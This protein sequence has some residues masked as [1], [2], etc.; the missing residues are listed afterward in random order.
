MR[1][2]EDEECLNQAGIRKTGGGRKKATDQLAGIDQAFQEVL[3]GHTAG[4]SMD[5]KV[6]WT[7][8]SRSEIAKGLKKEDSG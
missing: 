8:L 4:E 3:R 6:K 7:S 1:E 2:L 5:E